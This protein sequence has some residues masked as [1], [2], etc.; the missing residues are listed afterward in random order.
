MSNS[1]NFGKY[2]STS[3][4]EK[5]Y[6]LMILDQNFQKNRCGNEF[7]EYWIKI[8]KEFALKYL[9]NCRFTFNLKKSL[10]FLEET[11]PNITSASWKLIFWSI[12]KAQ[13]TVKKVVKLKKFW[14]T[15]IDELI[16]KTLRVDDS[17]SKFPKKS[18]RKWIFEY[19]SKIFK[20]FV[21]KYLEN[22]RFLFDLE[23]SLV[24]SKKRSRI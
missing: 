10:L 1:K 5:H 2:V 3:R 14:K 17:G 18:V 19:W 4:S 11:N 22:C 8:F 23:K 20:K 21:L 6:V 16:W 15:L 13:I 7:F 12:S 9:E 24:F